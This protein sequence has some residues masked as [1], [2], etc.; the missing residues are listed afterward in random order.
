LRAFL[1]PGSL[2]SIFTALREWARCEIALAQSFPSI[3]SKITRSGAQK[4]RK[5]C[6]TLDFGCTH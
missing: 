6:I 5:L 4:P 1:L 2:A 3:V